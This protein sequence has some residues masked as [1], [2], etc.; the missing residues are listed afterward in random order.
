MCS[1]LYSLMPCAIHPIRLI[2]FY[3]PFFHS[4]APPHLFIHPAFLPPSPF[5]FSLALA[6]GE[7]SWPIN[8]IMWLRRWG[9]GRC[10]T[11]M[12]GEWRNKWSHIL[13]HANWRWL[14]S[15]SKVFTQ[16]FTHVPGECISR[17]ASDWGEGLQTEIIRD[18]ESPGASWLAWNTDKLNSGLGVKERLR[19]S[20]RQGLIDFKQFRNFIQYLS[21][22]F[23]FL[24]S[25]G[26]FFFF[27]FWANFD[28]R[29][30]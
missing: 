2:W 13:L 22:K 7:P 17:G 29:I 10:R 27:T 1:Y 3:N 12:M 24:I 28:Y 6:V 19:C 14:L 5:L 23:S 30:R 11:K 21:I 9:K 20:E 16:L 18:I 4:I 25:W 15:C 26:N 8:V